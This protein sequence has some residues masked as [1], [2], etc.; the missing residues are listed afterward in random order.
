MS[1]NPYKTDLNKIDTNLNSKYKL[2]SETKSKS[3]WYQS[4]SQAKLQA[5]KKSLDI[6]KDEVETNIKKIKKIITYNR[7]Y[8]LKINQEN[9]NSNVFIRLLNAKKNQLKI[10]EINKIINKNNDI[11]IELNT[12]Y[13]NIIKEIKNKENEINSFLEFDYNKHTLILN[14]LDKEIDNSN[15]EKKY[16]KSKHDDFDYLIYDSVE[17]IKEIERKVCNLNKD[18]LSL[19]DFVT[20]ISK[21]ENH[22]E[23]SELLNTFYKKH[24]NQQP[25]QLLEKQKKS[26]KKL[27]SDLKKIT[28]EL[29]LKSQRE[30]RVIDKIIIDGNNLCHKTISNGGF[31]G[32]SA[33][34]AIVPE[35]LFKNLKFIIVFD[36]SIYK[37]YRYTEILNTL[38][39][40]ANFIVAE[41][42]ADETIINLANE[43]NYFILS[44]DKFI[45]YKAR[46]VIRRNGVFRHEVI[47]GRI[48]IN[49]LNINQKF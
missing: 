2:L 48:I 14:L 19:S 9:S 12:N 43:E 39:I 42:K 41:G 30:R 7:N 25:K 21:C 47:D 3:E 32:L 46:P 34:V 13:S 18:I 15:R 35:L 5:E 31:I 17:N 29:E 37:T 38:G 11:L 6:S 20:K 26:L 28:T 1:F 49:E 23:K 24:P 27:E 40:E 4:T 22:V 45:E 44:N 33:L 16:L 10:I 36:S 8:L